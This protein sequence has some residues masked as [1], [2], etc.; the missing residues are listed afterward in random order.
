MACT[1]KEVAASL[2]CDGPSV[3]ALEV[4]KPTQPRQENPPPLWLLTQ[5]SRRRATYTPT[6]QEPACLSH[7]W[8]TGFSVRQGSQN[9]FGAELL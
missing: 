2:R 1:V 9:S 6:T 4:S 5:L 8:E 3:D 7:S